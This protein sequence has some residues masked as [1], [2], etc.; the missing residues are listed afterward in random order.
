MSYTENEQTARRQTRAAR[1][2]HRAGSTV[3]YT[4]HAMYG[5]SAT[6]WSLNS[7]GLSIAS[8]GRTWLHTF[9][10]RDV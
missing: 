1:Q 8:A 7:Q 4:T 6:A 5:L 2:V 10:S 3:C 9:G